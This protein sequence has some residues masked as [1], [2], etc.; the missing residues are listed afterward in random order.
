[1]EDYNPFLDEDFRSAVKRFVHKYSGRRLDAD[2]VLSDA[3]LEYHK[4]RN[5]GEVKVIVSEKGYAFGICRNLVRNLLGKPY[6][7]DELPPEVEMAFYEDPV[8]ELNKRLESERKA[9][10]HEKLQASGSNCLEILQGKAEGKSSRELATTLKLT[11][12]TINSR[13][14][15][16]RKKARD[17]FIESLGEEARVLLKIFNPKRRREWYAEEFREKHAAKL[18]QLGY[19][20]FEEARDAAI[21]HLDKLFSFLFPHSNN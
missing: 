7:T 9:F 14:N 17:L 2:D 15:Q 20:S 10:I 1:M 6:D 19:S 21:S 18:K 8:I 16:C 3:Y 13:A 11:E 12:D 4:K 5:E